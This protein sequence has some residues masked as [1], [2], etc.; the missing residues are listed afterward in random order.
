MSLYNLLFDSNIDANQ[1]LAILGYTREDCGRFRD[2]YIDNGHIV[3][4][5]RNGGGNREDYQ[6]VF[7]VMRRHPWY[8]RDED[9]E[10]DCTYA[11]IF[12]EIP[13]GEMETFV[14]L[15]DQGRS[16]EEQ[17]DKLLSKVAL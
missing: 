16:P 3:I 8:V 9:D 5:T 11:N 12:F 14:A 15:L 1:L 13:K 2:I 4:H 17:W 6:D 7:D 10:F